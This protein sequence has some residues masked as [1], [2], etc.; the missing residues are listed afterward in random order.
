VPACLFN[1]ELANACAESIDVY[2]SIIIDDLLYYQQ[3]SPPTCLMV[4]S[5]ICSW[6]MSLAMTIA[7]F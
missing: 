2:K 3:I 4:K 6:R 1:S 5:A 7:M